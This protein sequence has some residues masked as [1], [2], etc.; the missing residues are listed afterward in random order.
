MTEFVDALKT[1]KQNDL[2]LGKVIDLINPEYQKKEDDEFAS[3]VKIIIGQQLSGSAA[4]TIIKRVENYL[5]EKNFNLKT[6][7]SASN[8]NLRLC[9]IS[10]AKV[11]YI[12]SFAETLIQTPKYFTI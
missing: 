9:G 2:N 8:K 7:E 5:G 3:L 4:K 6:I 1:L 11:N 12:K 10:N